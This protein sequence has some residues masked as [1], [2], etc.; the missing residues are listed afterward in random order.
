MNMLFEKKAR[1]N[2]DYHVEFEKHFYS[3]PHSLIHQEV[4]LRVTE[5]L[6]EVFHKG[7]VVAIHPRKFKSG[8]YSTLHEHMPTNHQFVDKVNAKQL[9][10]WAEEVGPRTFDFINATLKSR[11]FPEQSYRSCLG[12][13]S[14][15]KKHPYS[16]LEL[17]CQ[18]ALEA[19]AF[20]Y[21]AVKDELEWLSKQITLPA[22]EILPSHD[23]IR[24]N[25]YYQ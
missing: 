13:L 25:E 15:A 22:A 4:D 12:V 1:V 2:I 17:A 19:K 23:N 16:R 14:L 6:V 11:P 7:Q 21:K 10:S 5:H 3:V 8:G 20:S 9:L 24:G 18:E